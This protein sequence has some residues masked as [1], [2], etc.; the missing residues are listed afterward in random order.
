MKS[1]FEKEVLVFEILFNM[2]SPRPHL[3]SR[4][5]TPSKAE[6][7]QTSLPSSSSS[8]SSGPVCNPDTSSCRILCSSE[9]VNSNRLTVPSRP[10]YQYSTSLPEDYPELDSESDSE[11]AVADMISNS[12]AFAKRDG[13]CLDQVGDKLSELHLESQ[14]GSRVGS[15][16]TRQ[17]YD[18]SAECFE[19]IEE[20][21]HTFM[22]SVNLV[23]QLPTLKLQSQLP[24]AAKSD[25][26]LVI[27]HEFCC[28]NVLFYVI[29][30]NYQELCGLSLFGRQV[31]VIL[32]S[33]LKNERCLQIFDSDVIHG[34]DITY[35]MQNL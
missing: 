27:W 30:C 28:G 8:H 14:N 19:R 32:S 9:P 5:S 6:V 23:R 22:P 35:D 7:T 24:T 10:K 34:L 3:R 1:P 17:R 31:A 2:F 26:F 20:Y 11:E 18:G 25:F 4:S 12:D 16:L 13:V 33:N 29:F 15:G 21:S